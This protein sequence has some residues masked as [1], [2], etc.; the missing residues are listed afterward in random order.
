MLNCCI[1]A[2]RMPE[3]YTFFSGAQQSTKQD[4]GASEVLSAPG[5]PSLLGL[6]RVL[7]AGVTEVAAIAAEV[8]GLTH[9]ASP[10]AKSS[11][12]DAEIVFDSSSESVAGPSTALFPCHSTII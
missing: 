1:A 10:A 2:A 7:A 3:F 6:G 5:G 9:S 12:S 4:S 8:A 11:A